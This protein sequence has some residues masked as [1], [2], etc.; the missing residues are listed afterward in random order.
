MRFSEAVEEFLFEKAI[1]TTQATQAYYR[2]CLRYFQ[3]ATGIE[4]LGEFTPT[5]ITRYLHSKR[6]LA[7]ASV[8]NYRRGLAVFARWCYRRKL[9]D[10]DPFDVLPRQRRDRN[11]RPSTFTKEQVLAIL[12]EAKAGQNAERD[13]ALILT[14]LDTGIRVG[15]VSNL[16]LQDIDW[17]QSVLT[18][19]GK[20]GER[21][22]PISGKTKHAL[23]KYVERARRAPISEHHVFVTREGAALTPDR[24]GMNLRRLAKR[25][26]VTGPKLGPHTYRHTCA[27]NYIMAGGDAF[28][29][30][31]LLGHSDIKT[32]AVYV[33][34]S[35]ADIKRMHARHSPVLNML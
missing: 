31:R 10:E 6:D 12:A 16:L 3:D 25:A 7:R 23:R 21:D 26:G 34:M 35:N 29:L 8:A 30:S 32:T 1:D 15:E 4:H 20:T 19:S 2:N 27:V 11:E 24:I 13:T 14:L 5:A 9:V 18:V 17:K 28:T 33:R 22:V